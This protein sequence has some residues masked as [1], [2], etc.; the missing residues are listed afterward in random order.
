MT[1]RGRIVAA[2]ACRPVDRPPV[3]GWLGLTAWAATLERWREESG[4]ADLDLAEYFGYDPGFLQAPVES[5]PFPHFE[6]E[7]YEDDGESWTYRDW[8][9][10]TMR[11]RKDGN[12]LPDYVANP[13]TSPGDWARYKAERLQPALSGRLERLDDFVAKA[14]GADRPVQV[15]GFPYGMFGTPRDLLGVER[16]LLA[17]YDE[18]QM[19]RDIIATHADLWLELYSAVAERLDIDHIHIWEDMSGKQGSLI[20]MPM[21]E[22]FMMPSYDRLAAFARDR[23]VPVISVDSDGYTDELFE[24]MAAHGVNSFFPF[25]VQAGNDVVQFRREHPG[26]SVWG[27]LDKR[28]LALDRAAIHRELD[29]AQELFALGGY[30]VGFDH[31]IPPD[32][33]WSGYRYF[34]NELKAIVG[35]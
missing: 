8:R 10:I 18:P 26:V 28:S 2:L 21:V 16:L 31:A 15:G 11:N 3:I 7:V 33:P 27:G 4:I 23:R 19:L 25:E 14:A 20:S 22:E 9:G 30:I 35:V 6:H 34:M 12:T 24:T 17:F 29:R 32:V 1:N 5:G 13:I